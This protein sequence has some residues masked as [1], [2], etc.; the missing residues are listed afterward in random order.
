MGRP[1]RALGEFWKREG[2]TPGARGDMLLARGK[3]GDWYA[4]REAGAPSGQPPGA[5]SLLLWR[6]RPLPPDA[7]NPQR[8]PAPAA[9]TAA[10]LP[11]VTAGTI[12]TR[13]GQPG[14]PGLFFIGRGGGAGAAGV[15]DPAGGFAPA[16]LGAVHRGRASHA[17]IGQWAAGA[18]RGGAPGRATRG[19]HGS[20]HHDV[21]ASNGA[22]GCQ[23]LVQEGA[24]RDGKTQVLLALF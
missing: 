8:Q 2:L 7:P 6:I 24:S 12:C 20:L 4:A 17:G 14:M 18:G 5:P 10:L 19:G 11:P 23:L 9:D 13:L 21:Q 1:L 3:D 16:R 15:Q 22:A